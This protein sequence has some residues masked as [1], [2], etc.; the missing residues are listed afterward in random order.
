MIAGFDSSASLGTDDLL[1]PLDT[2]SGIDIEARREP[3]LSE[4]V[5]A[6][7]VVEVLAAKDVAKSTTEPR[8]FDEFI[9]VRQALALCGRVW[10]LCS[11]RLCSRPTSDKINTSTAHGTHSLL[12]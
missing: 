4:G 2:A 7:E 6:L 1:G 9:F 12:R 5:V 3:D 11:G 10:G 8:S